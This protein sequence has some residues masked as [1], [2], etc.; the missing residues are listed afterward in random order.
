LTK[1]QSFRV[2]SDLIF[3]SVFDFSL[4]FNFYVSIHHD[5]KT[6]FKTCFKACF[7]A[8]FKSAVV[9]AT[10][11][12]DDSVMMTAKI[13]FFTL[14]AVFAKQTAVTVAAIAYEISLT[15]ALSFYTVSWN[16]FWKEKNIYLNIKTLNKFLYQKF[17]VIIIKKIKQK[18]NAK[19]Y[20]TVLQN[21]LIT[22][23]CIDT[24]AD[25]ILNI[26]DDEE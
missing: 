14:A 3:N 7:K 6:T 25:F 22:I 10:A 2:N 19:K 12:I 20:N 13:K 24:A 11:V 8:C 23:K 16:V 21:S 5:K 26:K 9:K 1:S 17:N 4:W 18:I 15:S